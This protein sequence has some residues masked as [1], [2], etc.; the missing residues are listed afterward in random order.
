MD[1][2]QKH[3]FT[4]NYHLHVR[5]MQDISIYYEGSVTF[6]PLTI[7]LKPIV[8]LITATF[9]KSSNCI[10]YLQLL[11]FWS[12]LKNFKVFDVLNDISLI[13]T[14]QLIVFWN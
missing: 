10:K 14:S 13:F 11:N 9:T 6:W 1:I 4:L 2:Q 12:K 7:W 8:H 3:M 5:I